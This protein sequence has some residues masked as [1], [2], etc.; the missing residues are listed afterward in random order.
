ME[1]EIERIG[2]VT[3]ITLP[4][5]VLDANYSR[6]FKEDV[7]PILETNKKVV[8]DMS[9]MSFVDSSG[10]G[11]LLSCLRRIKGAGGELKICAVSSPVFGVF[12]LIRLDRIFDFYDSR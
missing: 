11:A 8:F 3:I 2:D 12:R 5:D 9:R 1:F 10:C 7:A 4:G 6:E